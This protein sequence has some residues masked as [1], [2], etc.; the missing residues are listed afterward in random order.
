MTTYQWILKNYRA[1]NFYTGWVT[2]WSGTTTRDLSGFWSPLSYSFNQNWCGLIKPR[3][4]QN[5]LGLSCAKLRLSLISFGLNYILLFFW[6]TNM[7]L[8]CQFGL[9]ISQN[10][11]MFSLE[12]LYPKNILA[13]SKNVLGLEKNL[14]Q[15]EI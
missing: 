4:N 12:K 6:M 14:A 10:S 2:N 11:K 7:V 13:F 1:L 15:K 9:G 5:K 8:I 3:N